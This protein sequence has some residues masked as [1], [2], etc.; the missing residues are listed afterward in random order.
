M[1]KEDKANIV[2]AKINNVLGLFILFF[3]SVILIAIIFTD[4]TIG[5]MTNLVA[6]LIL[7][8]VGAGMMISAKKKIKAINNQ[9]S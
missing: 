9:S 1:T 2:S 5:Q 7:V 6:G 4:T 3:G 8:S